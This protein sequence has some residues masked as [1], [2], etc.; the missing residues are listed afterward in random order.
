MNTDGNTAPNP[1]EN[2][3]RDQG[4]VP[5]SPDVIAPNGW[6][7]HPFEQVE[8]SALMTEVGKVPE[9]SPQVDLMGAW[10]WSI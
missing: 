8:G 1:H 4:I 6:N 2:S 3:A 9:G 7:T 10:D 5:T